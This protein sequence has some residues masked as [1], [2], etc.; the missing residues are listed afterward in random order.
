MAGSGGAPGFAHV[1][2]QPIVD[3]RGALVGYELLFRHAAAA[4]AVDRA[5]QEE[6]AG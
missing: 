3:A 6:R 2:R 1:A 5:G 4:S